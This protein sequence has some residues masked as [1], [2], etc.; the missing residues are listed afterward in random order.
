MRKVYIAGA[1]RTAIG[2]FNGTLKDIAAV[3][4]ATAVARDLLA[5]SGVTA[6]D[7][8]EVIFGNVL[9]AG[10]G[11]NVA[12]QIGI[13]SGIPV[14]VPA[15]TVNKVCASGMKAV[16]LGCQSIAAGE[17]EVVVCGGTENMDQ[18]PY[19]VRGARF[20]LRMNDSTMVDSMVQE[21]LWC[22]I[23]DYHMGITA[24]NIAEKYEI[25][26]REQDQFSAL[27]QQKAARA[28]AN[29]E[30]AEEIVPV[31]VKKRTET[32]EFKE[33]EHPRAG[34][35]VAVLS[36]LKPAFKKDGTVTAGNASGINDG[37]AALILVSE[38][39]VKEHQIRPLAEL[40]SF[41]SV[42][43]DPA[44]MGIGPSS[45]ISKLLGKTGLSIDDIDIFELNEAFASQA[46]AVLKETGIDPEKV[47]L[48]GGAVALG[49]PI[50]ASGARILVTLVHAMKKRGLR[51][52]LASLCI[53]GGMGM[54]TLVQL[55]E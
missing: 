26:R 49:H 23:N 46:I 20:G 48:N 5:T 52:G 43:V 18:A 1:R 51:T 22:A 45:A 39:I 13:K 24:E 12:R 14:Q 17:T 34:T 19:L 4:L 15:Y 3:D 2:T 41:A 9:S 32:I 37:A 7:V 53:G 35:T 36:K 27:S 11:Q 31:P 47:N 10:L 29:G 8:G 54:A 21:G 30:F 33:D 28:I 40:I 55:V 42:G 6:E 16:Q 44:L 38:D 50:G 25:S